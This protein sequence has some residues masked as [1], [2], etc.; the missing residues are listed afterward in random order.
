MFLA[1]FSKLYTLSYI[2]K[3]EESFY[4]LTSGRGFTLQD[5]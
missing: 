5:I 1:I 3:D 2:N 4:C